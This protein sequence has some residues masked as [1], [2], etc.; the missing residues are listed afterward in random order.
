MAPGLSYPAP[1]RTVISPRGLEGNFFLAPGAVLSV[2]FN[3]EQ[4]LQPLE[5]CHA[6]CLPLIETEVNSEVW[7]IQSKL[8][9][10]LISSLA[11]YP[12]EIPHLILIRD[13]VPLDLKPMRDSG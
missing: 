5:E 13:S 11:P 2:R 7:A 10:T 8:G 6:L 4:M 12:L 9:R 3:C 1:S